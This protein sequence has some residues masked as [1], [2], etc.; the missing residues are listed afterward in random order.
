MAKAAGCFLFARWLC[1][2]LVEIVWGHICFSGGFFVRD[3]FG[4]L[5]RYQACALNFNSYLKDGVQI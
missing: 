4:P 1:P 3:V 5:A 2:A